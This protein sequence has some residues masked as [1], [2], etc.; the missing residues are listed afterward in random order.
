VDDLSILLAAWLVVGAVFFGVPA[1]YFVY[2]KKSSS[3]TWNL[4]IDKTYLPSAAILIPVHNEEKVIRLKLENTAK[5]VY[6]KEKLEILIVNDSSTDG[7][8]QEINQYIAA[9]PAQKISVF[10]SQVHLGKTGCLNNA[11]KTVES[12]VV[13]I[14]DVDCFWPSDI[15][16]K[17]LSYLSDPNVGAITARELLLNPGDSWVT[18]GEEFYDSTIQSVRIG[19][20]KVHSTIFFQGGFAAY[21][22]SVLTEF[23]HA[24]DDSGTALDIVQSN[25]RA[26]LIPEV[27]F[28]TVSPTTWS[29]KVAIKIRRASHLQ[30]LWARSLNLLLHDKLAMPKRI[31]IPEILLHIFNPVLLIVFAALSVAVMVETP[32][33]ALLFAI[34]IGGFFLVRRT[35]M[36][37][38]ELIQNNLILL[39]S[40]ASFFTKR[41]FTFWKP[42]QESRSALSEQVLREKQLI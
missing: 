11:L 14:S 42:V 21:K 18:V 38:L 24:T 17:A 37:A 29:N 27:G 40:L 12:D 6:P 3:A 15:L 9:H 35:R 4:N 20:S 22:R 13:I 2:M 30:H 7:T 8:L 36:T 10:D 5:V 32:M 33:L 39:A 31:A 28:F 41:N 34:L 25:R 23:N 1:A 26:L 19:E 16:A